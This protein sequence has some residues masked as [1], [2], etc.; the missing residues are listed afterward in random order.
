MCGRVYM[1]IVAKDLVWLRSPHLARSMVA[2]PAPQ[3][4][5]KSCCSDGLYLTSDHA[6]V[7]RQTEIVINDNNTRL[8]NIQMHV[9]AEDYKISKVGGPLKF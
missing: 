6:I 9:L 4:N 3:F 5:C 8:I 1:T 2:E 7:T